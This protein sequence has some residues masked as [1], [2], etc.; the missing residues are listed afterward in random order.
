ME[1]EISSAPLTTDAGLLPILQFDEPTR[2]TAQCA[3][4]IHDGRNPLRIEHSLLSMVRQPFYGIVAD[5][6]VPNDHD[7]LRS[8][9]VV[10]LNA[11][12]LP[13]DP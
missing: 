7:T 6:E 9:P 5:S 3:A 4:A 1:V 11:D 12:R 10:K 8:D 2:L 13:D